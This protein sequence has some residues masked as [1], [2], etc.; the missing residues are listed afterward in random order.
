VLCVLKFIYMSLF[1]FFKNRVKYMD[2]F[3]LDRGI[4]VID[5]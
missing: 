1:V 2:I 5:N 3:S 4:L